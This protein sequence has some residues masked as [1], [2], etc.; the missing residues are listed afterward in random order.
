MCHEP[1]RVHLSQPSYCS[2]VHVVR[3]S[4]CLSRLCA[5]RRFQM[6]FYRPGWHESLGVAGLAC[7]FR[8]GAGRIF[9]VKA[10]LLLSYVLCVCAFLHKHADN[11]YANQTL[12]RVRAPLA[13]NCTT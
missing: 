5:L 13:S 1:G 11:A 12:P 3:S 2:R 4:R 7:G 8:P 10:V 9:N 6:A